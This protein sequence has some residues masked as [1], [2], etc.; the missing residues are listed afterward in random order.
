MKIRHIHIFFAIIIILGGGILLS[1]ELG[2]FATT[3]RGGTFG[4]GSGRGRQAHS[5]SSDS[6]IETANINI[7]SEL[8]ESD[9]LNGELEDISQIRGSFTL[10]EVELLYGIPSKAIIEAFNLS[11]DTNPATFRLNNLKEIY[12]P[13]ELEGE[14]Y[15][16]ETDTVKVFVSLYTGIPYISEETFYLPEQTVD[17]LLRNNKLTGEEKEYWEKHIFNLLMIEN[18]VNDKFTIE[19]DET[20]YLTG[21]YIVQKGRI[22]DNISIAGRTTIAELLTM[23]IDETIF[24][25]LTGL[26]LPDEMN[27]SV[28]DYA[29]SNGIEFGEIRGKL[30]SYLSIGDQ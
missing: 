19:E 1:S 22:T 2:L 27:I 11:K 5:L 9:R 23:G 18:I 6:L 20:D 30:E 24:Q 15:E 4:S 12:Q 13:V 29:A 7:S 10:N 3:G 16:V 25:N 8:L 17:Y 21:D 14:M 28:R 26:E